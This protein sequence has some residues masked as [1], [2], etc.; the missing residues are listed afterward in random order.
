V[1]VCACVCVCVYIYV[2]L[3]VCLCVCVH[4]RFLMA[5]V[6]IAVLANAFFFLNFFPALGP[7]GERCVCVYV[8]V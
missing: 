2:Y 6:L 8:C 4:V 5:T 3:H 1:C 7:E